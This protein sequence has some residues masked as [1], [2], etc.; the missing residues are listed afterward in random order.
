MAKLDPKTTGSSEGRAQD[1]KKI[2]PDP[3]TGNQQSWDRLWNVFHKSP[4][5]K[6]RYETEREI[7]QYYQKAAK[8]ISHDVPLLERSHSRHAVHRSVKAHTAALMSN[9][10]NA[11]FVKVEPR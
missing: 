1:H 9:K 10:K 6:E 5:C 4:D 3:I 11:A 2:A 8:S 7:L